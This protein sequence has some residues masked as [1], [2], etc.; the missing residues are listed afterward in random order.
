LVNSGGSSPATVNGAGVFTVN[1]TGVFVISAHILL[2]NASAVTN[3]LYSISLWLEHNDTAVVRDIENPLNAG[4]HTL[5]LSTTRY[6]QS[7]DT[8]KFRA[9][10]NTGQTYQVYTGATY[11]NISIAKVA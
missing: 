6:L 3:Q 11:S 5:R 9:S 7:G 8:L 2:N 1:G 4:L 10:T